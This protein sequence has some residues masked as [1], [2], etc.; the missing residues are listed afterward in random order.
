[1]ESSEEKK[2]MKLNFGKKQK[3]MKTPFQIAIETFNEYGWPIVQCR[4][5][6][7]VKNHPDGTNPLNMMPC[8]CSNPSWEKIRV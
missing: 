5:C 3:E 7:Y 1:M 2:K 8:R 4:N 6:G